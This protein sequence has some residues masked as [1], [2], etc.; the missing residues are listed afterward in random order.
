MKK[1]LAVAVVVICI[2][3]VAGILL[4]KPN[5]NPPPEPTPQPVEQ[6]PLSETI[7]VR[8]R[9]TPNESPRVFVDTKWP[10]IL[11]LSNYSKQEIINDQ[12]YESIIPY[13]DEINVVSEGITSVEESDNLMS[14]KQYHYDV[15]FER[16]NNDIYLSLVVTQDIRISLGDSEVGGLR[17]NKWKDTY[18]VDCNTSDLVQLKDI[19]NFANYKAVILDE[20]NRQAKANNYTLAGDGELTKLSDTQR[21][22]IKDGKLIIYFE[23]ASIAPYLLGEL[24]FEMPFMYDSYSHKF[25]R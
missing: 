1:V 12:I 3:L 2:V 22:Y 25:T 4:W 5:D 14:T 15:D 20:V 8:T 24:E 7:E 11:N 21:F 10:E 9:N 6:T 13:I 19:C 17:S 18:V 16:Y 23:P